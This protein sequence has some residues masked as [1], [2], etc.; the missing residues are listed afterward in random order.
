MLWV[1]WHCSVLM[2]QRAA[3]S[4]HILVFSLMRRGSWQLSH[5]VGI[6]RPCCGDRRCL[7]VGWNV[8]G[9]RRRQQRGSGT[10]WSAMFPGE[11]RLP[12]LAL[13][14]LGKR[15]LQ[16]CDFSSPQYNCG[17]RLLCS[18]NPQLLSHRIYKQCCCS[19]GH[20]RSILA[21]SEYHLSMNCSLSVSR[22][23]TQVSFDVGP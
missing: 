10:N 15:W 19:Q 18:P 21:H 7:G 8:W 14:F 13:R 11:E 2:M 16:W 4:W 1:R 20:A 6:W 5:L 9:R 12:H 3:P 17:Y 23:S 22:H